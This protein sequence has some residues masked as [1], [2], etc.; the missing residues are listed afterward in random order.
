MKWVLL[1]VYKSFTKYKSKKGCIRV[2]RY[3]NT[4]TWIIYRGK[5]HGLSRYIRDAYRD[6]GNMEF[7]IKNSEK[8]LKHEER[9]VKLISI[10]EG[11]VKH[12]SSLTP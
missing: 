3:F 2:L 6:Y 8:D 12:F 1:P 4:D 9:H 10:T 11:Q 7:G 5:K